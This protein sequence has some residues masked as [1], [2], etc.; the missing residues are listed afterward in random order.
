[1]PQPI[2]PTSS[3]PR[4]HLLALALGSALLAGCA[5]PP[6]ARDLPGSTPLDTPAHWTEP[7]PATPERA[8]RDW[9]RTFGNPE[10]NWVMELSLAANRDLHIA[11]ARV[12][13]A[14]ALVDGA[15]AA[16]RPQLGV[17]AALQRG[18]SSSADPK[19]QLSSAGLQASWELDVAGRLGLAATAAGADADSAAWA[20]RATRNLVA[21]ETAST[22]LAW[23]S[24]AQ[25]AALAQQAAELAER[26]LKVAQR[27]FEAGRLT[28]IELDRLQ[29]ESAQEQ[30]NAG[31][32]AG[33][34]Q[35]RLHQLAVLTGRSQAPELALPTLALNP[36]AAP[37]ATLP[38]TLLEQ[39][40]DVQRAARALD[41]ALARLGVARREVYP[42]LQFNWA[43]QKERLAVQ[44][45]SAAPQ[46]VL[47]YGLSLSL[48]L[49]DGGRIQ[50]NIAIH[51]ARAQEAMADYEK[52]LLSALA[53]AE[54]ALA[55]W[56]AAAAGAQSWQQVQ[57][58]G[59]SAA[60][61][62]Q[63]LY[64]AGLAD[65]GVVLQAQ[66]EQLRA[67]DGQLQAQGAWWGATVALHRAFAGTL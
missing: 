13:Q 62:S 15:D 4:R 23:H 8:S 65:L 1:M 55:Q 56:N 53:D 29:A 58:S 12:Q 54:T 60:R 7:T 10:L 52:A 57:A 25:R 3:S 16:G 33:E 35:V 37:V 34:R 11:Q 31:Q 9:W 2:S 61:R 51:E 66:R 32:L 24:L 43:A 26:R 20:L 63:R 48:P 17:A 41:A 46:T 45:S 6:S 64:D 5:T 30:A 44:G 39:R 38:A 36:P 28:A 21:A 19:T 27:Q 47:G 50:A 18:R 49:L 42:Q 14:R 40:P 67:Q 59:D 22:Y